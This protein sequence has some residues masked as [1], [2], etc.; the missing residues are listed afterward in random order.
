MNDKKI[1]APSILSA[2]FKNLS[3]QIRYAELG[4]ADWIHCDVMDGKFVPNI[5]FGPLIVS[6]VRKSTKLPV[7]VHLMIEKPD[8]FLEDFA[9]AGADYISVHREEVVHLHRTISKIHE[10]KCKA[11]VVLNPA[12]PLN[13]LENILEY[14][15]LVLL[16]SVNPGFGGQTFIESTLKKIK[17]LKKIR[18]E[19]SLNFLIE[20]DGGI[21]KKNIKAIS[22]AGCNVFVTGSSIFNSYNITAAAVELKNLIS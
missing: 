21:D 2:D 1:L 22:K 17:E 20:V 13:T 19:N 4:G 3:Q 10:L 5:T 8:N 18:S 16:M 12:T 7:D 6:A 14:V 15:D 11:G 9:R